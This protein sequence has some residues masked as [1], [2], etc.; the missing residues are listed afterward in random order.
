MR[1]LAVACLMLLSVAACSVTDPSGAP[2]QHTVT[3]TVM[4]PAEMFAALYQP[5]QDSLLARVLGFVV[6][7]SWAAVIN[8]N[9][10]TELVPLPNQP[11]ELIRFA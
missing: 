7:D 11:L 5:K 6:P 8:G 1:G 2:K 4:V 3:G 10:G 9:V